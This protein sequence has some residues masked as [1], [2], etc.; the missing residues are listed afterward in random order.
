MFPCPETDYQP[1]PSHPYTF[2]SGVAYA[3]F[4]RPSRRFPQSVRDPS[5][6]VL[7]IPGRPRARRRQRRPTAA[8][9]TSAKSSSTPQTSGISGPEPTHYGSA[10]ESPHT[11]AAAPAALLRCR[12]PPLPLVR[13]RISTKWIRGR[14]RLREQR[15]SAVLGGN[16]RVGLEVL[17]NLNVTGR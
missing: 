3:L 17:E 4:A 8:R 2:I 11:T 1:N 6:G 12:W 7:Y 9:R 14:S 5:W 10:G 13:I 16:M 15:L